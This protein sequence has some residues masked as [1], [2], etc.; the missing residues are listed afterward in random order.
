VYVLAGDAE[1]SLPKFAGQ[2]AY[3]AILLG[4][5][6][7]RPGYT[8]QVGTLTGRLVEAL[9]CDFLLVKPTAYR[10]PIGEPYARFASGVPSK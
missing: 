4:A 10:S 7:H 9:G 8:A 3:D 2:N 1:V 5:L 6:T